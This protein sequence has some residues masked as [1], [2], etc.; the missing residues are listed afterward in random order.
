MFSFKN[1]YNNNKVENVYFLFFF[2]G[3]KI[4]FYF[5]KV[6]KRMFKVLEN[7]DFPPP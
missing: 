1:I 5:L 6:I 7:K 3:V 2:L 4:D